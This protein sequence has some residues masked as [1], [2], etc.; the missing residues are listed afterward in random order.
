MAASVK[1]VAS[2]ASTSQNSKGFFLLSATCATAQDS[3]TTARGAGQSTAELTHHGAA[4][5]DTPPKNR[6]ADPDPR[7]LTVVTF[8]A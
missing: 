6:V 1:L 4:G 2:T 3:H 7:H 8:N 5:G